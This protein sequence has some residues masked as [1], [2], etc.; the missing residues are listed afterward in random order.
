LEG[1]VSK[2]NIDLAA[3]EALLTLESTISVL[4][5][6]ALSHRLLEDG[7]NVAAQRLCIL[8]PLLAKADVLPRERH[9]KIEQLVLRLIISVTNNN[10]MLCESLGQTGLIPAISAIIKGNF[11]ELA[12]YADSGKAL[13]EPKLESVILAL[14]SLINFAECSQSSRLSMNRTDNAGESFVEWLVAAFT[15]RAGK[16]S[17]VCIP[18][19]NLGSK[20]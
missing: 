3:P 6:S 4:E 1:M 8:G 12:E 19:L 18:L 16:A 13:D 15:R 20:C 14:G 11:L 5:F 9:D 2:D 10:S 7:Y 17:E